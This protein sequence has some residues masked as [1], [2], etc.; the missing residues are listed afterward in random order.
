[1]NRT[2]YH[3][4]LCPFSRRI[5][6]HLAEK[7]LDADY[8]EE[9]FWERRAAFSR[10]NPAVEVPVLAE[11]GGKVFP[12]SHAISEYIENTYPEPRLLGTGIEGAAETRRLIFWCD[13]KLFQDVTWP[14]LGEKVMR[15]LLNM[16]APE[17]HMLHGAARSLVYHCE[18]F[19][20]LLQD[21]RWLA[22]N[23]YSLADIALASHIS[24]LDYLSIMKW[25]EYPALK[26]WYA[27]MKSRPSF[28]ALLSDRIS[29]FPP[30][31]HYSN[32]DF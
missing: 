28:R 32:P 13:I 25:N 24:V 21:R 20:S 30:P 3:F 1:M 5:R 26:H 2:L 10:L 22:G 6:L 27:L 16:G 19:E 23:E 18:Y 17:S 12:E 8:I 4:S 9:P 31:P 15:Y 14:V 29:G 7:K 11:P